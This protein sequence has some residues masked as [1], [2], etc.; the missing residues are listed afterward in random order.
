MNYGQFLE[1]LMGMSETSW[2][3]HAN[4][5]S[6]WSRLAILP[7]LTFAIWSRVWVGWG[8]LALVAIVL[9][10][11][12]INPRVFPEPKSTDN[13]MSK[14]VLGERVWLNRNR[15]PISE[16]HRKMANL[17]NVGTALG[18]IPYLWGLWR[19]EIWPTLAGVALLVTGKLWFL[20]RMVWLF[21]ETEAQRSN[22][23]I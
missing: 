5:W 9:I 7:L 10:W 8:S 15:A 23:D 13:W 6:G 21:E 18:L 22:C 17:L 20:D 4:P 14:G 19:L 11:V 3:R 16:R 12:W 2:K 1:R